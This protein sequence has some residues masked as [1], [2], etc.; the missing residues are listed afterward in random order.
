VRN[1]AKEVKQAKSRKGKDGKTYRFRPS[2]SVP[3]SG[4]DD[5]DEWKQ[6][7]KRKSRLDK[8]FEDPDEK[9][10]KP[11]RKQVIAKAVDFVEIRIPIPFC[12]STAIP[13]LQESF[14]IDFWKE[15]LD[16]CS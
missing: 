14:G 1:E 3:D 9:P 7:K 16:T 6:R 10:A 12:V 2:E 5:F 13:I 4:A 15:I 8:Y 11:T